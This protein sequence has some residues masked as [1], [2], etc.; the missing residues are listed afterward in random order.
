MSFDKEF[1]KGKKLAITFV[2][3]YGIIVIC[4]IAFIGWAIIKTMQH[5]E[6]I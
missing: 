6:V 1:N 3:I 4:I 5:F 2:V